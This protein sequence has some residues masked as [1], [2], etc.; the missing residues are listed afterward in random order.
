MDI[1][2]P[3][4]PVALG[5]LVLS[6]EPTSV[7]VIGNLAIVGVNTSA[8]YINVSGEVNII[9]FSTPAN[10]TIL[11]TI[12]MGGQPECVT[13]KLFSNS[14]LRACYHSKLRSSASLLEYFRK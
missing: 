12:E 6:G 8:G 4:A 7:A 13:P 5:T 3:A 11:H 10:P 2:A 9:D 14:V 1:Q